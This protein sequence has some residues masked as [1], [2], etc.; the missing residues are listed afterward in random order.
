MRILFT[1]IL[2]CISFKLFS[3]VKTDTIIK[4][5]ILEC[6]FSYKY[7]N[8]IFVKYILYKGGGGCNRSKFHFKTGKVKNSATSDDYSH[9]G[10]DIGHLSP[11]E[12]FAYDCRLDSLTFFFICKM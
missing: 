8:P 1:F 12:D 6:H 7:R 2:I 11:S 4:T 3:Q 5:E 9:S 10:Y